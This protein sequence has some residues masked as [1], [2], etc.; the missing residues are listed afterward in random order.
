MDNRKAALQALIAT[1][2]RDEEGLWVLAFLVASD[3][4][5]NSLCFL[6]GVGGCAR[7]LLGEKTLRGVRGG[8]IFRGFM[9]LVTCVLAF[10]VWSLV[11]CQHSRLHFSLCTTKPAEDIS[12]VCGMVAA[13]NLA[14]RSGVCY[15]APQVGPLL[16]PRLKLQWA[17]LALAC[18]K[19]FATI[20]EAT[21]LNGS[22]QPELA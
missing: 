19:W 16:M 1:G 22:F 10:P 6:A 9:T 17:V 8:A 4:R 14:P 18:S 15:W 11:T 5:S 20:Q 7:G 3:L 21:V 12:I 2:I 13:W